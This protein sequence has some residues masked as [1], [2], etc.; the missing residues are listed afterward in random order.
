MRLL[1]ALGLI[2]VVGLG[3]AFHPSDNLP[4]RE[5]GSS[6]LCQVRGGGCLG[7]Q[8]VNCAFPGTD[9]PN[10]NC[11]CLGGDMTKTATTATC[12]DPGDGGDRECSIYSSCDTCNNG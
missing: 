9:C 8:T 5:V 11:N 2:L 12:S 7:C 10:G 1:L 6:E 3:A 4:G